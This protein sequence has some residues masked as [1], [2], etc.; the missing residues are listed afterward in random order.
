MNYKEL[1]EDLLNKLEY[2]HHTRYFAVKLF[3]KDAQVY[4]RKSFD[5]LFKYY[6]FKGI[7]E[8]TLAKALYEL[9][10]RGK[11]CMDLQKIVFFKYS[12]PKIKFLLEGDI[13]YF[14]LKD[15]YIKNSKYTVTYL[16]RLLNKTKI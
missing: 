9:G 2:T 12:D 10:F 8:K 14:P 4:R 13:F 15:E 7:S 5:D 16:N 6:R 11:I 3:K 1:K